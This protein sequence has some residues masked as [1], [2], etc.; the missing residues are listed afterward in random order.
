ML[1]SLEQVTVAIQQGNW[2]VVNQWLHQWI[3]QQPSSE[4]V[5]PVGCQQALNLALIVLEQGDF[6]ARWDIARIFPKLGSSAIAPLIEMI[7]DETAELDQRWFA[8]RILGEFDS[9]EVIT[10]L[11]NLL[12]TSENDDLIAIAASALASLDRSA[13]EAL[14]G[15]LSHPDSRVPAARALAQIHHSDVVLPLLTVVRDQD[16]RIRAIAIEALSNFDHDEIPTVLIDALQDLNASVRK[17]AV[18]GLGVRAKGITDCDLLVHLKPLLYDLNLEVCRQ[19]AIALG[20]LGTDEAA[21]ALAEVLRSPYSPVPLRITIIQVLVWMERQPA[22]QWLQQSLA[23]LSDEE[24]L[25]AIQA[26]GR[27]ETHSLKPYATDFLLDL[28][29]S[30]HTAIAT[31]AIRQAIAHA[32]GQLA[33]QRAIPALEQLQQDAHDSVRLHAIAALKQFRLNV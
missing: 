18:I 27:I 8:G 12:N 1:N 5:D 33:E 21:M 23:N 11:V 2:S 20:R 30:N 4:A 19:T 3:G 28:L 10:T 14:V 6:Q 7:E 32:L 9:P 16:S 29:Q 24:I 22:L 15:L 13:I 25:E 26:I 31:A 17:E